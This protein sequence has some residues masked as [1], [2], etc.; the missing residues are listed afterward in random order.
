MSKLLPKLMR[1]GRAGSKSDRAY[2]ETVRRID[3]IS[4]G[5][6]LL[7]TA[8]S[9]ACEMGSGDLH[10]NGDNKMGLDCVRPTD[11]S[12]DTTVETAM[13]PSNPVTQKTNHVPGSATTLGS[14]IAT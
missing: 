14:V 6:E 1:L 10:E 7:Q 4:H 5:I 2:A 8:E 11:E 3:M 12:G 9:A 13:N